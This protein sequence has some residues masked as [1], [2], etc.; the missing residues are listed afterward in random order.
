MKKKSFLR[1][2]K[3]QWQ[4]ILFMQCELQAHR[5]K[6]SNILQTKVLHS[7]SDK[8]NIWIKN[9]YFEQLQ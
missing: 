5:E 1:P 2:L 7:K 4:W 3:I 9:G 6:I 8:I